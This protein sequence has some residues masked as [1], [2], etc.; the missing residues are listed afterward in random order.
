MRR[1][2]KVT[3]R[4]K[5]IITGQKNDRTVGHDVFPCEKMMTISLGA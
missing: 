5:A 1:Y 4:S 2:Q 3:E